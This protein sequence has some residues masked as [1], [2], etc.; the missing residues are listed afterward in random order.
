MRNEDQP[1][2]KLKTEREY[3]LAAL[4]L[5]MQALLT[6]MALIEHLA[7]QGVLSEKDCERMGS[8]VAVRHRAFICTM[9]EQNQWEEIRKV[10]SYTIEKG[11]EAEREVQQ[12]VQETLRKRGRESG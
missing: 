7:E 10:V 9:F 4:A 5:G 3:T 8:R 6:A 11:E 12:F 2:K 1:L